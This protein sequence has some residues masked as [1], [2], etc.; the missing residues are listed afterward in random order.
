M[1]IIQKYS[2]NVFLPEKL[3]PGDEGTTTPGNVEK[4]PVT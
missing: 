3:G 4:Y 1:I 2:P